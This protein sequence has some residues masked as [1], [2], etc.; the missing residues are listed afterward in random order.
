[1]NV[2][3]ESCGVVLLN[4]LDEL[5]V[6]RTTGRGRWD[7]PKGTRDA[8]ELSIDA[9]VRELEEETSLYIDGTLLVHVGEFDYLPTKRLHLFGVLV[10]KHAVDLLLLKCRTTFVD[11]ATGNRL[12]EVDAYAWQPIADLPSWCGPNL[13]RV[14]HQ[15]NWECLRDGPVLTH[16][17]YSRASP[18]D[19]L[20]LGRQ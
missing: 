12:P 5:L 9:A 8:E 10:Q 13:A 16:V 14:L 3:S 18:S 20:Q 7:L 2:H 17:A 19:G 1:M 11:I 4:T 15:V 6:C